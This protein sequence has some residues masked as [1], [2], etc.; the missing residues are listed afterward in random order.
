[1]RPLTVAEDR[2]VGGIV[3]DNSLALGDG[4]V[5]LCYRLSVVFKWW[6]PLE[7]NID[8]QR[9]LLSETEPLRLA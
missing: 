3:P 5:A 1:M 7:V 2:G 8:V 9:I 4:I 6:S